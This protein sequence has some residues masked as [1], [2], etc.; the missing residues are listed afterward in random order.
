[1]S[2][3]AAMESPRDLALRLAELST[4]YEVA[5]GLVGAR[6]HAQIGF[7]VVLTSMGALG[8][9]SG[10][11]FVID[12]RGRYRLLYSSLAGVAAAESV[13]VPEPAR[14]WMMREGAFALDPAAQRALGGLRDRLVDT[15]DA[16]IGAAIIDR[17]GL[18]G[19]LVFGAPL[20]G[21]DHAAASRSMLDSIAALSAQA[22]DAA[23]GRAPRGGRPQRPSARAARSMEALRAAY[24]ALRSMVGASAA[25]LE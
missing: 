12:E 3:D 1:M 10:A 8:A 14:Q 4:L 16:A 6:D 11:A 15:F 13:V 19:F 20:L 7:R 17:S 25:L 21:N 9:R 22:L 18:L 5:R 2:R 24:P 23:T